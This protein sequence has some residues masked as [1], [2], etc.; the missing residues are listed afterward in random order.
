M[1]E[2]VAPCSC[3]FNGAGVQDFAPG[4]CISI[5]GG[6]QAKSTWQDDIDAEREQTCSRGRGGKR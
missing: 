4:S 2:D 3:I 1:A 6:G 5:R